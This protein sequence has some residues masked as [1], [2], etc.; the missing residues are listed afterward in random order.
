MFQNGLPP[1]AARPREVPGNRAGEGIADVV[2][3]VTTLHRGRRFASRHFLRSYAL[4]VLSVGIVTR[5]LLIL[6]RFGFRPAPGMLM[7]I[8]VVMTFWYV[9]RG[10]DNVL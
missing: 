1:S 5:A 9:E 2:V 7:L 4:A 8:P 10:P 6:D 3:G